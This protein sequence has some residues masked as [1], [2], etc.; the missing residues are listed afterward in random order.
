MHNAASTSVSV[1]GYESSRSPNVADTATT[2][3]W[4][5]EAPTGV[6]FPRRTAPL[7]PSCTTIVARGGMEHKG[8]GAAAD[9]S[10]TA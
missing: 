3:P 2:A 6:L 4:G 10:D 5:T 7:P 1:E 9:G 8:P